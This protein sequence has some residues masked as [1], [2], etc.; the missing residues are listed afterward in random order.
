MMGGVW[1]MTLV[2]FAVGLPVKFASAQVNI[3]RHRDEVVVKRAERLAQRLSRGVGAAGHTWSVVDEA[4]HTYALAG[5]TTA[6][7]APMGRV[8]TMA[9]DGRDS[10]GEGPIIVVGGYQED[11]SATGRDSGGEG[12]IIVV[13]GY[14]DAL[15]HMQEVYGAEVRY[16]ELL[17]ADILSLPGFED[18]IGAFF[19][20]IVSDSVHGQPLLHFF[21]MLEV[22]SIGASD[23][24]YLPA[25]PARPGRAFPSDPYF[26]LQW[27]IDVTKLSEA[28]WHPFTPKL[29]RPVRIGV[30]DSGINEQDRAAAGLDGVRAVHHVAIAPTTGYALRH[31][32]AVTTLLADAA[33]DGDGVVGLVGNWSESECWRGQ[34]SLLDRIQVELYSYNVG[35]WGPISVEVARAIYQSIE[36]GV[37]V[38]NLSLRTAESPSI[39]AA[40]Q[41]AL[42]ANIIVVAA[43]GNYHANA[44]QKPTSFPANIE[45]VIAVTSTDRY[46]RLSKTAA[47]QGY[48][49]AAPGEDV[50]VGGPGNTWYKGTGTSFAAP[51][52]VAAVALMRAAKPDLT[53]EEARAALQASSSRL[54]GS[55]IRPGRR[56]EGGLLNALAA[57]N[58][59]LPPG[60]RARWVSVPRLCG[61]GGLF[62]L[63]TAGFANA[64]ASELPQEVELSGNSPNPFSSSTTIRYGLPEAQHV[65]LAVYNLLGQEVRVLVDDL[66]DAGYH[67]VDLQAH[68]L[69]SGVYLYRLETAEGSFSN[70]MVLTR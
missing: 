4:G 1:V 39:A 56:N 19:D 13:G 6:D 26:P 29:N 21:R 48:D 33:N 32:L 23:A 54:V 70:R 5:Y 42:D 41:A 67:S 65:R 7:V 15:R 18:P 34:S 8:T 53:P 61:A 22:A 69:P 24:D 28:A 49:I 40:I 57:L 12:P 52:V 35:D 51:H 47:N 9:T 66:V 2:F 3:E 63:A 46:G 64:S 38:I 30:I 37:D 60:E 58:S 68:D 36:D 17:K 45:G 55:V 25:P 59:V 44:R 14:Q 31:G 20:I 62:D 43:A 11:V 27:N 50:I 10:G 16:D